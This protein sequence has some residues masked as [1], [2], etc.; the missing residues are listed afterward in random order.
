M[1]CVSCTVFFS[2][3]YFTGFSFQRMGIIL[4]PSLSPQR[5]IQHHHDAEADGKENRP[6]VGVLSL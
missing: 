5:H 2:L 6:D 1:I 3:L 4:S